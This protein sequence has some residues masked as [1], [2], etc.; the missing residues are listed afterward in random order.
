MQDNSPA[1]FSLCVSTVAAASLSPVFP[2][3]TFVSSFQIVSENQTHILF[4]YFF[5][6]ELCDENQVLHVIYRQ[7]NTLYR[8]DMTNKFK[9]KSTT[10]H[11]D[12][13]S[14]LMVI[15]VNLSNKFLNLC[16]IDRES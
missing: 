12:V 6:V 4:N 5:A 8:C 9:G 14:L 11:V 2:A 10:F 7:T 15:V 16:Y 3:G 1:E 13:Q